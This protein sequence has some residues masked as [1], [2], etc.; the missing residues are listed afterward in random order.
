MQLLKKTFQILLAQ[1]SLLGLRWPSP[2]HARRPRPDSLKDVSNALEA[3]HAELKGQ[4]AKGA[5][6]RNGE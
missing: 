4:K 2:K 5:L 3:H 6:C 1:C